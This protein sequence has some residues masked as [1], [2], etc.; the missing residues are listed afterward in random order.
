[1]LA[2]G[3]VHILPWANSLLHRIPYFSL[4]TQHPGQGAR[5]L[6]EKPEPWGA[7]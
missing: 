2:G 7:G 1:M 3:M 5:I 4:P 6:L